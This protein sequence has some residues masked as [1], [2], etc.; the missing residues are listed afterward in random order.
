M[1]KI[2]FFCLLVVFV[3][4]AY[5]SSI[6]A[7]NKQPVEISA[8]NSLEWDKNNNKYI[9][10]EDVVVKYGDVNILAELLEAYYDEDTSELNRISKIIVTDNVKITSDDYT[11]Y[12]DRAIYDIQKSYITM[13]G[14]NL[15]IE[16]PQENIIAKDK[17]EYDI[18]AKKFLAIGDANII[19]GEQI[20]TA[21]KIIAYFDNID[22]KSNNLEFKKAKAMGNVVI[23]N[24]KE[25]IKGDKA[26]YN[27]LTKIVEITG[28]VVILEQE[29]NSLQ[30]AKVI[31]D[32]N[33][34]ISKIY[35]FENKNTKADKR[36]K[37]IFYPK[38]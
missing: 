29:N 32:L 22:A 19:R 13:T 17:M 37:G 6:Y 25:K 3:N 10:K 14:K 7:E 33:S 34:G 30:G 35:A 12:G 4:I 38:E 31:I 26:S 15:K 18:V 8:K 9:A 36:V 11:A 27:A 2:V 23:E 16:T 28:K 1:K 20:L 24:G 21:D 5:S